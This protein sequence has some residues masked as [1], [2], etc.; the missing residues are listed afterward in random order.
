MEFLLV[1]GLRQAQADIIL[2]KQRLRRMIDLLPSVIIDVF[3]R[4]ANMGYSV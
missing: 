4:E 3:V 1:T 2:R